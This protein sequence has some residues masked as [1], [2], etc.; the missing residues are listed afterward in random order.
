[1]TEGALIGRGEATQLATIEQIDP[2][3]VNFTQ[4]SAE[5]LALREAIKSGRWKSAT[6]ARMSSCWRT[7][8]SIR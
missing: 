5:L 2:I 3:Y 8:V 6:K 4:S 7:R 1:V